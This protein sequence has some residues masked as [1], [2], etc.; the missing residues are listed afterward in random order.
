MSKFTDQEKNDKILAYIDNEL[1]K[2]DS[3]EI[4]K[5]IDSNPEAKNKYEKF[6]STKTFFSQ[7]FEP[8]QDQKLDNEIK[9][10]IEDYVLEKTKKSNSLFFDYFIKIKNSFSFPNFAAGGA[11]A[12]FVGYL[13]LSS[14]P[15]FTNVA[16]MNAAFNLNDKDVRKFEEVLELKRG[17]IDIALLENEINSVIKD[18]YSAVAVMERNIKT[19]GSK[20]TDDVIKIGD[21]IINIK[22]IDDCF[23]LEIITND[24]STTQ[25]ICK[26]VNDEWKF[27]E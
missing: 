24:I 14:I 22:R 6:K 25:S 20:S 13:S 15:T 5:Y 12:G 3:I 1:S 8:Y 9:N 17:S 27:I 26:N 19:K 11:I 4:K 16:T 18:K 2:E 23:E 7:A 10:K 21:T